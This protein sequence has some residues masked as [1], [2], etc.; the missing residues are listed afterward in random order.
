[1]IINANNMYD[2]KMTKEEAKKMDALIEEASA[3]YPKALPC[4]QKANELKP[5]D[6]YTMISLKELYYKL[7]MTNEYNEVKARL[8]ALEEK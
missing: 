8:D 5:N 3:L 7:K 1:M 2:V 4:M 6:K